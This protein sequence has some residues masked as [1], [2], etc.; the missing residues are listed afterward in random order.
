[1]LVYPK[2]STTPS[3]WGFSAENPTEQMSDDKDCKE[4]FKTFLD[5]EKLRQAQRHS[6]SL[7]E[8]P[9]SMQEVE[10]LSVS[11]FKRFAYSVNKLR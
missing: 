7:D 2:N 4:W 5:E 1:V 6:Q 9:A 8:I 10:R 3:S 11:L